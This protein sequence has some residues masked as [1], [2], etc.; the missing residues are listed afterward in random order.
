MSYQNLL[1]RF[2]RPG[3]V[4]WMAVRPGRREP[5]RICEALVLTPDQGIQGDHYAGISQHKRQVT[6]IQR[7]HLDV[8][9]RLL[10]R[11]VEP[12]ML[13]RNLV[14]SG[15]NLVALKG[16]WIRLGTQVVLEVTGACH[17]CT[18][19][20]E[21]LGEGGFNALRGHGGMTATVIQGG[22]LILGD[23]VFRI[24][25]AGETLDLFPAATSS[26]DRP[27]PDA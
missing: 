14:I 9:S 21:C 11:P 2:P 20:E 27:V 4:E 8:V 10:G 26:T 17:P 18:R 5:L 6:L 3:Q 1:T 19:M 15:I 24:D 13:R 7:E 25:R 16:Q 22:R 23:A 12:W